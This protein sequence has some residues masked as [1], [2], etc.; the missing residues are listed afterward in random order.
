MMY[1]T[2][3]YTLLPNPKPQPPK[4]VYNSKSDS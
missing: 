2:Q 4:K 3:I 1:V